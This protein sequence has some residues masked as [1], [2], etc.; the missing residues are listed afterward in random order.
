MAAIRQTFL[1]PQVVRDASIR[2]A[3]DNMNHSSEPR[4]GHGFPLLL[5]HFPIPADVKLKLTI[6]SMG[7]MAYNAVES[8]LLERLSLD[9]RIYKIR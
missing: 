8:L 5:L 4:V 7:F 9:P 1:F 6:S 3:N 2:I